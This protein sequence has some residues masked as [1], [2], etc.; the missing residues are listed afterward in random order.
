MIRFCIVKLAFSEK[1]QS[2]ELTIECFQI[3]S[4]VFTFL[5]LLFGFISF[6]IR[7]KLGEH[8]D[9]PPLSRFV[10]QL[11]KIVVEETDI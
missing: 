11:V 5:T 10:D 1:T 6:L 7:Q 4:V 8:S 2:T 9:K 3:C